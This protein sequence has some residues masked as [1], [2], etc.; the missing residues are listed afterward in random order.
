MCRYLF[1]YRDVKA[2]ISNRH[3]RADEIE[4]TKGQVAQCTHVQHCG[5]KGAAGIPGHQYRGYGAAI[6]QR[7]AEVAC[8]QIVRF[9]GV[10]IHS[11]SNEQGQILL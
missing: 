1:F 11:S 5:V 3:Q 4:K 10:A 8:A 2:H 9:V 7:A 6:F